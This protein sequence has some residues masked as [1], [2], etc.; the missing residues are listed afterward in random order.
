M[1]VLFFILIVGLVIV[2]VMGCGVLC[3]GL[4]IGIGILVEF[5]CDELDYVWEWFECNV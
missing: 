4:D 1:W 5:L 3:D 2:F